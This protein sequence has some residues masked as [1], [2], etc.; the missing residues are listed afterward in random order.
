[1]TYSFVSIGSAAFVYLALFETHKWLRV[2]LTNRWVVYTGTISYGLYLLHKIPFD[3]IQLFHLDKY[4]A[5]AWTSG[6]A[7]SYAIATLSWNLLEK[8]FLSLK[9]F[10]KSNETVHVP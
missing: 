2:V 7:A 6:L 9:R 3:F 5:L 8:P 1:M 4:P 10:F